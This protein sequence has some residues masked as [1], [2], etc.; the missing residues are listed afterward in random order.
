MS[1]P[2]INVT[3]L[4]DVLLVLLIIFMVVSP[5]KPSA[6]KADAPAEPDLHTPVKENPLSIVL[7]VG[8][9]NSLK[10]NGEELSAAVDDPAAVIVRM[11]QI[12]AQREANGVLS[13]RARSGSADRIEKTV[14][15]KAPRSIGYGQVVK[16]VD[17]AKLAGANPIALQLDRLD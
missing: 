14:F 4:I 6:F 16:V 8:S 11:K 12:F 15:V 5:L 10:M 3:P 2:E 13:E 9:D 17:A 7:T 1:K